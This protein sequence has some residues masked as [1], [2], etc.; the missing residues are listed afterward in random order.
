MKYQGAHSDY[1][2][3]TFGRWILGI[4]W[5]TGM[6]LLATEAPVTENPTA[7]APVA[8]SHEP[9]NQPLVIDGVV[10][11]PLRVAEVPAQQTGLLQ[12]FAIR[13]G[14]RVEAGQLMASLDDRVARHDLRKAE[15]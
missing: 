1:P 10:L 12:S 7:E 6:P 13:E 2:Q 11:R 15:L 4:V 3:F 5:L 14:E 9:E 8:Q